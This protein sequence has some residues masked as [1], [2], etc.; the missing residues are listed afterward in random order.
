M[1]SVSLS[2]GT[3]SPVSADSST[4][5]R[6]PH[7]AAVGRDP[8]ARLEQHDVARHQLVGR[9]DLRDRP[10]ADPHLGDQL[11]L[12]AAMAGSAAPPARTRAR[13]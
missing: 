4:D 3:D 8:V 10:G 1:A 11:P 12:S 6:R 9:H 5:R 7:E 2:T 13:R